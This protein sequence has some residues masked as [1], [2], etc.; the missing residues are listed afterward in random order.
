MIN[1]LRIFSKPGTC[2]VVIAM[3]NMF[4]QGELPGETPTRSAGSDISSFTVLHQS[5]LEVYSQC[6]NPA[7]NKP[8]WFPAG[9]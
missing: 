6:C 3:R 4:V 7:V 5:A 9:M 2:S 1:K 8:G